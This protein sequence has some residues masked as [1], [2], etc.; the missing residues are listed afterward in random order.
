MKKILFVLLLLV[1]LVGCENLLTDP[2]GITLERIQVSEYL[3]IQSNYISY[4]DMDSVTHNINTLRPVRIV[5]SLD[6]K[7]YITSRNT[8]DPQ[9]KDYVYT[10][11]VV[12]LP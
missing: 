10:V 9:P 1:L 2:N 8:I 11:Y 6:N 3:V 7:I 4:I 12:E 5:F